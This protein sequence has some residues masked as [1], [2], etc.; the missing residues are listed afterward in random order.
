MERL[1]E[2]N[3]FRGRDGVCVCSIIW[4]FLLGAKLILGPLVHFPALADFLSPLRTHSVPL[5]AERALLK[6]CWE[7]FVSL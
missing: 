3:S 6:I 7:S 5:P 1:C 2:M 4:L